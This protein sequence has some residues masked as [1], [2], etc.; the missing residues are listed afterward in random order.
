M[1]KQFKTYFLLILL[2]AFTGN[3]Y[4][5][6]FGFNELLKQSPDQL[7]PFCVPNTS[8]NRAFLFDSGI[9]IKFITND[10]IFITTTPRWINDQ[11]N[12]KKLSDFYFEFTP[13][14]AL[15]DTA[16]I[17]HNVN[18]IHNGQSPL[19][20]SYTGKDVIVGVVDQGLD[21]NH[22]DF[23]D[24]NG[25]TRVLRYWDHTFNGPNPAQ[26]YGY[27]QLWDSTAINNGSCTS[28]EETTAHG[29]TVA[30]MAVGNAG[31]NGTQKGMAPDANIIIVET[32]FNLPNW[33]LTI[34]D[35]VDYIFAVADSMNMPAVV[36][37]SLGSYFGSHD[38]TDPA[39]QMI[40][41][42]LD[43]HPGRIV[44][45]AAG[46]SGEQGKYHCHNDVTSDTSFVWFLNNS[47]AQLGANTIFFDLWA[48]MTDATWDYA[49]GADIPGSPYNF[50]GRTSFR[51]ATNSLG[52]VIYDTLWNNGNRIATFEIY[53]EQV[54]NNYHM[55]ILSK[56]DSTAYYFRFETKGSGAYD[57]WSGAW[58]GYN[59]MVTN[60]PSPADLPEI[61]HY[62]APETLQSIVSSW[63]CSDKVVTVGVFRNKSSY[64]DKNGNLYYNG[65]VTPGALNPG[66]SK[67]PTRNGIIKPDVAAAGDVT[68]TAAPMWIVNNPA[69]NPFLDSGGWHGRNGGTSMASPIVAGIAALYLER[70]NFAS[71][72]NFKTDLFNTSYTDAFTGTSLPNNAWGYGKPDAFALLQEQQL[73]TVT[74]AISVNGNQLE[75]TTD[76]GYQWLLD[77]AWI[78][79]EY[80]STYTPLP[81][82]GD[83]QVISYNSDGCPAYSNTLTVAAGIDEADQELI[84]LY[85]NPGKGIFHINASTTYELVDIVDVTGRP[86]SYH[87][88][89]ISH[90]EIVEPI[91]G[92]YFVVIKDQ[93]QNIRTVSL[94][95]E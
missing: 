75:S 23:L 34:A 7:A 64:W 87:E 78:P 50:R 66:S 19:P 73:N 83:Y 95:I 16:R 48:D 77:G 93:H 14:V 67:G 24:A 39:A 10:W 11:K 28:L 61:I 27:G 82:Y 33:T 47:S 85:P 18:P 74:P 46:N 63:N 9:Q 58:L 26:P 17:W 22:P 79:G 29:T 54:G 81:P 53:P 25:N 56:V 60:I 80:Q 92:Q 3:T 20:S 45:C 30:G 13:P 15:A 88:I 8:A 52:G 35:A 68:L 70:C 90:F 6:K 89:G 84:K 49:F 40:D 62:A 41:A 42:L 55:Q 59:N 5:Q 76:F 1:A 57:L 36:N 4:A 71:Y 51:A 12:D 86:I 32:N 38:A 65:S 44:V 43:E 91:N 72:S 21:W 31:A 69:Y 2:I 37:L 94:I